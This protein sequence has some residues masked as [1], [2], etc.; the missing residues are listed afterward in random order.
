MSR[1]KKPKIVKELAGTLRPHREKPSLELPSE[2]PSPPEW[3]T[4]LAL[5]E[6]ERVVG[7]LGPTGILSRIDSSA[8]TVYCCLWAKFVESVQGGEPINMAH[9]AE[10]RRYAALFG[11]DPASR[12]KL[13][14]A[15]PTQEP[16]NSKWD[17]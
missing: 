8:L 13:P 2:L 15:K 6:F 12:E 5:E 9:Y 14:P 10:M 11:L 17:L 7:K 16:S 1:P 3:L 4:G